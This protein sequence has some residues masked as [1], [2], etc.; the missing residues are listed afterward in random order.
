MPPSI[1]LTHYYSRHLIQYLNQHFAGHGLQEPG[2]RLGLRGYTCALDDFSALI[3][4]AE[5]IS[6]DPL[7]ALTVASRSLPPGHGILGLVLQAC[8]TLGEACLLGHQLQRL[9][10]SGLFSK[11]EIKDDVVEATF[12]SR[13]FEPQLTAAFI[14]YCMAN[15]F[16]IANTL[17]GGSVLNGSLLQAQSIQFRHGP[18]A[19]LKR[20]Q[21]LL[22]S[23]EI[24]FAQPVDKII[25]RR[26]LMDQPLP[27][28]DGREK[29]L[30]LDEARKRMVEINGSRLLSEQ[31]SQLLNQ[32]EGHLAGFSAAAC[33]DQL[34]ISVSTLKRRLQQENT[35]FQRLLEQARLQHARRLLEATQL[36]A[37]EIARRSGFT[38]ASAFS[39]AFRRH[40]DKTPLTFRR[41]F[42][43]ADNQHQ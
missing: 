29:Q 26:A 5:I 14:E 39:R 35:S 25:I 18:R 2:T 30:L 27:G 24:L 33:A 28:S 12:D 1:R 17:A 16:S 3:H 22:N 6:K 41:D 32:N 23:E 10:R 37:E 31:I 43:C 42:L 19:S 38:N 4:Q 13:A 34:N 7:F 20:Y 8:N 15:Y 9:S 36:T 21:Q 40:F 11:V